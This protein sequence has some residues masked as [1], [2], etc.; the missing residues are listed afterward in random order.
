MPQLELALFDIT[1]VISS[2]VQPPT[3]APNTNSNPVRLPVQPQARIPNHEASKLTEPGNEESA[4][5]RQS[6]TDN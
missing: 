4:L 1:R 5:E 3:S 2:M 6:I